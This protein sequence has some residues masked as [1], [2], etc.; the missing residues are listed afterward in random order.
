MLTETSFNL[1]LQL[2]LN[3]IHAV[4]QL[5]TSMGFLKSG[6]SKR[7]NN[8]ASEIPVKLEDSNQDKSV[9]SSKKQ[10]F[11]LSFVSCSRSAA[12]EMDHTSS[13]SWC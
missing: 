8:V 4:V 1:I 9:G 2:H 3:P 11:F 7:K 10:V 5:R 6:G 12:F 13:G